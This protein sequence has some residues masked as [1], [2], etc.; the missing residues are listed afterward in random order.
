MSAV[1][2]IA[3]GV[4]LFVAYWVREIH[5][6]PHPEPEPLLVYDLSRIDPYVESRC[7]DYVPEEWVA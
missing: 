7:P 3:V 4:V 5:N 1:E 6:A 2:W